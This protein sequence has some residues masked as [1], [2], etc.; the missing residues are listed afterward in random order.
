MGTIE[1][2]GLGVWRARVVYG[3]FDGGS[4][5]GL[6]WF[7]SPSLNQHWDSHPFARGCQGCLCSVIFAHQSGAA[8][9][10]T[11]SVWGETAG[12][13]SRRNNAPGVCWLHKCGAETFQWTPRGEVQLWEQS[14]CW[15]C[16][17]L[18]IWEQESVRASD[19]WLFS[20]AGLP[21]GLLSSLCA[22]VWCWTL[23]WPVSL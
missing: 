17:V 14:T 13:R 16:W 9:E 2:T 7:C 10:G 8:L 19:I 3:L 5:F 6:D 4:W 11:A 20:L 22:R 12:K 1:E 15:E 21:A 18:S 23:V